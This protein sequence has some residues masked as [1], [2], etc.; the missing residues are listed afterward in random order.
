MGTVWCLVSVWVTETLCRW[1]QAFNIWCIVPPMELLPGMGFTLRLILMFLG[2][3][4]MNIQHSKVM[5][6]IK[7]R[8]ERRGGT[9]GRLGMT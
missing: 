4:S 3:A 1:K 7:Q 6:G 5:S 2:Y 8:A 9:E